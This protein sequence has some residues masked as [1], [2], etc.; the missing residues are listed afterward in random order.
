MRVPVI[1]TPMGDDVPQIVC[2]RTTESVVEGIKQ[3]VFQ[4]HALIEEARQI[5]ENYDWK[6]I[7]ENNLLKWYFEVLDRNNMA[8]TARRIYH[9]STINKV[10]D[11]MMFKYLDGARVDLVGSSDFKYKSELFIQDTQEVIYG[12]EIKCGMFAQSARKYHRNYAWKITDEK[13]NEFLQPYDAKTKGFT[14]PSK[15]QVWEIPWLGCRL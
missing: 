2:E 10:Q 1:G 7:V 9:Q 5:A 4:R 3:F 8:N 11:T 6:I 14:W 12:C 13:G 15:V